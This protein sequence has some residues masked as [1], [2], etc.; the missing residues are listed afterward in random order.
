MRTGTEWHDDRT[1][2][3]SNTTE[4][5]NAGQQQQANVSTQPVAIATPVANAATLA[6]TSFKMNDQTVGERI[7]YSVF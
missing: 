5:E 3:Q 7:K 6:I 1:L 4:P 2:R